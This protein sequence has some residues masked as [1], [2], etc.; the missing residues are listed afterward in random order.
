[1]SSHISPYR[2]VFAVTHLSPK[3]PLETIANIPLI[4]YMEIS[5]KVKESIN[6]F[7]NK[8]TSKE[9]ATELEITIFYLESD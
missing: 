3:S 4:F 5:V 7:R 2:S 8:N 9:H 1:M 6:T